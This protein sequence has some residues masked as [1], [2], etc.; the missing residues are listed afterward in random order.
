M[1]I[2]E[3]LYN[4]SK[5]RKLQFND[6][7]FERDHNDIIKELKRIILSCER[8]AGFKIHVRGFQVIE[9]YETIKKLQ[10][11]HYDSINRVKKKF[12]KE[13]IYEEIN[14]NDSDVVVLLVSYYI[15][16]SKGMYKI[17]NTMIY[18][19]VFLD[20]YYFNI[21]GV[22][23][24]P[25]LQIVDG[26]SFTKS[27]KKKEH[28]LVCKTIFGPIN[29]MLNPKYNSLCTIDGEVLDCVIYS[30]NIFNKF[31]N[32]VIYLLTKFGLYG[33]MEFLELEHIYFSYT[34]PDFDK[35]IWYTFMTGKSVYISVPKEIYNNDL[36]TQNFI[37]TIIIDTTSKST[38]KDIESTDYWAIRIAKSFN[39][40]NNVSKGYTTLQ[41]I[42]MLLDKT[43]QAYIQ[44]PI[45][46]KQSIYHI[47]RW[48]MREFN[49]L[50]S[51]SNYS[52]KGKRI[53]L[54][55]YL[56]SLYANQ[57]A[58]NL[59]RINEKNKDT[60]LKK[61][62]DVLNIEPT[63]LINYISRSSIVDDM[64]LPNDN[65][66]KIGIK[67]SFKGPSGL[68]NENVQ[69]GN[70]YGKK[71]SKKNKGVNLPIKFR[72]IDLSHIGK[73]DLYS[74]PKSDPGLGGILCPT[75]EIYDNKYLYDHQEPN[76]WRENYKNLINNLEFI[77][78]KEQ[79]FEIKTKLN[80]FV[81]KTVKNDKEEFI[82]KENKDS[83]QLFTIDESS[84][85]YK[86][87]KIKA[88]VYGIS[89]ELDTKDI[90]NNF[91]N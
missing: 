63:Y 39:Y 79:L 73:L 53:R 60:T 26:V 17:L 25:L 28:I 32:V 43:T 37:G 72:H 64:D 71:K 69:S 51:K 7:L 3:M 81:T 57:L 59:F 54:A 5:K 67:Y 85:E 74:S 40:D 87:S 91:W 44:L 49:S 20:K 6:S 80:P 66:G 12:L 18:V 77:K 13:N 19:P 22:K 1:H 90:N 11:A 21:G 35:D 10:A 84:E 2:K 33:A 24:S 36:V 15:E 50:V 9:D 89:I 38:L 48:M 55:E 82:M 76:K 8:Y 68:G 45:E 78:R 56:A 14:L 31:N 23:Y 41:S 29:M 62:T 58:N 27:T 16:D 42:E 75:T 46:D 47:L 86:N 34:E 70:S 65:D 83:V 52:L 30:A 61:L 88:D 4:I